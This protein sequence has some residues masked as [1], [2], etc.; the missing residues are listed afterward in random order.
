[1]EQKFAFFDVDKTL[2]RMDSLLA[3]LFYTLT[4][5]PRAFC[6]FPRLL[7]MMIGYMFGL[8]NTKKA[9]EEMLYVIKYLTAEELEDFFQRV[10][11]TKGLYA[12]A[13]AELIKRKQEGYTVILVSASPECYLKY[14][15][16]MPEVDY[17][18]G[19]VLVMQ[20]GEYLNII[21]GE[22]CKGIEK[23]RRIIKLL[24]QEGLT[25]NREE[26]CSYSDSLLDDLPL[27]D[28]AQQQYLVNTKKTKNGCINLR[29]K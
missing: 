25:I 14:F 17:V 7:L 8:I 29:W 22:N 24:D 4:R 12:D 15:T 10:I 21:Q 18:L 26:S 23:V 1:M 13:Q 2:I 9:K 28:L 5:K 3:L 27:L 19:T 20:N 16:K 6:G 11:L